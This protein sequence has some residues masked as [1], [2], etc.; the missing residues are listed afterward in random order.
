[1]VAISATLPHEAA[2]LSSH[3][4]HWVTAIWQFFQASFY[5]GGRQSCTTI[6]SERSA[7]NWKTYEKT[8]ANHR[9][10]I[11]LF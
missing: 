4:Y 1:M 11:K 3:S 6:F 9:H 10:F 2:S 7:S 5:R 8:Y